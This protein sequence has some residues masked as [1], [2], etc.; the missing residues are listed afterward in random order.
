MEDCR[1]FGKLCVMLNDVSISNAC[2]LPM[3]DRVNKC[4]APERD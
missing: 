3:L 4:D 2:L 1:Q